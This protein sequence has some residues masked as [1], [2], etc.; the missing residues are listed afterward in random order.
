[1]HFLSGGI[2]MQELWSKY[3][4]DKDNFVALNRKKITIL[5]NGKK[6]TETPASLSPAEGLA[7]VWDLTAEVYSLTG[8][9]DVES[10]LQRDV[11]V[12]KRSGMAHQGQS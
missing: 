3:A 4:V 6:E 10:R 11:V 5:R 8:K 7:C 2:V 12:L 9:Y 1:M